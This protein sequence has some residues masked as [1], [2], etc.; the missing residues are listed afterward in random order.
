VRIVRFG[1]GGVPQAA[2]MDFAQPRPIFTNSECG[3][4]G[5]AFDPGFA[6]NGYIYFFITRTNAVQEIV[7]YTANGDLGQDPTVIV[8]N[9][10]T[11]GQNHDGGGVGIGPDGYLYW[12]IGDLGN[13]T[14]VDADLTTSAAKVGRARRDGT[15]PTDNPFFDGAGPNYDFIWARGFR[16]PFT[17]TF[18]PS[19]GALWVNVVGTSYEQVFVVN[20]GDHAG[21]NDYEN[22]QP[23]G[24][25]TP[26][27][28]YRTGA[29]ETFN[30][31]SVVRAGGVVT[32][33]TTN[34]SRVRA[35][36]RIDVTGVGDPSFN[37]TLYVA[38]APLAPNA[39][40]FTAAQAGP[41]A[42]SS[43]GSIATLNQGRSISGG[44]FYDGT[45]F[46]AAYRGN[47]FYGDYVSSRMMRATVGPGTTVTSVDYYAT[48]IGSAIDTAVGP[49]GALYYAGLTGN[50]YR[51]RYNATA[52]GIVLSQQN[53][54]TD[55]G[56][57]A[58]FYVSLQQDPGAPIT[59]DVARTAG[60]A[61]LGVQSGAQ[62]TFTSANWMDPQPVMIAAQQDGDSSN[63]TATFTVSAAG[64]GPETVEALSID[65]DASGFAVSRAIVPIGEGMSDTFTVALSAA[66]AANVTVTVARTSGDTEVNV[67]QGASLTFT[68]ADFATPQPVTITAADD[69]DATDE[70]A[71]IEISAPGL[72]AATV[73]IDVTDD[74]ARP[75]V[76]TSTPARSAVLAALYSY[77]LVADAN[78]APTFS[79]IT[80]P[81]GMTI[82]ATSGLIQWTPASTGTVTVNVRAANGVP[83]DATQSFEVVVRPDRP[84]T[85]VVTKPEP[86]EV[87]FGTM[88]E[89]FGDG[90]DDVGTDQA[91][92]LVDGVVGFTDPGSMN[93]FH[94]G[95]EHNRWDT[96]QY[97]DGPHALMI[98]VRDTAAQTGTCAVNV[99]IDNTT[100]QIDGGVA[101]QGGL[102]EGGPGA[103]AAARPDAAVLADGAPTDPAGDVGGGCGCSAATG[104][105]RS[106]AAL[107][108]LAA[109]LL[110]V[111]RRHHGLR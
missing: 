10:A 100:P 96:T 30:I 70:T 81:A 27:I 1:P 79:L 39:T 103:D 33:T 67:T 92:F 38:T 8:P 57:R 9:L 95:G 84:P 41:D 62:L 72:T 45:Q 17:L 61:N 102:P 24:F 29:S 12:S 47:F 104:Q 99:T 107:L 94:F 4:V 14:G 18:Q 91:E 26:V 44:A 89:F 40:T 73:Q 7:R 25:I 37:G 35:G 111:R 82:T 60:S 76:I 48:Q 15:L 2:P 58:A 16:N 97:A 55:E 105:R 49:D 88:A 71:T 75:P 6:V 68:P 101:D 52:Q 21:Y 28:K 85:C 56:A 90:I 54:W 51:V 108:G 110:L 53:L 19:T 32:F 106:S 78:P 64:L 13:G 3:L 11:R 59:V 46:P 69:P 34:P 43:G 65:D 42:S 80:P 23:A 83:P 87:V 20:R 74:D 98:R 5:M 22:N 93:H 86:G 31:M 66:P 109:L 50:I 63:D 36:E 77:Q